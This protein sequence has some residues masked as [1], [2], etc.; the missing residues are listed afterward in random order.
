MSDRAVL[1]KLCHGPV[2]GVALARELGISRSAVHKRIEALRQAGVEILVQP[3]LG[4]R[5]AHPLQLLDREAIADA[6]GSDARG[7]LQALTVEYEIASTQ[8]AALSVPAPQQGCAVWLAERQVA[9]QG[10][11]GRVW[12][13]PLAANLYLSLSRRFERG[14]FA[15]SGLSLVVGVVLAEALRDLGFIQVGVKW[16]NDLMVE[17]KKLGGI[18]VQLRGEANGPCE[19][20]VGLGINA[21]MP[22]GYAAAIDQ[23]WCDLSQLDGGKTISRN[24][25]AAAVLDRLLPALTRFELEGLTPFLPRWQTL[26]ALA[27]RQVHVL[28]G[29]RVNQGVALGITETGAL[30]VRQSDGERIYHS[31]EVSLRAA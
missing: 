1:E 30:R 14:F 29:Q 2:T 17:G 9:G 13:S 27:G 26:D 7:Q 20:V 15:L 4:Y 11:R 19:A 22:A 28:D 16:P 31:G 6:L 8:T 3:G 5:L 18:L 12:A 24:V 23:P 21:R 10:R 25:L